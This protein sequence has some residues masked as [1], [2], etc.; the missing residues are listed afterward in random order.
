MFATFTTF[1]RHNSRETRVITA[2]IIFTSERKH[3]RK[4]PSSGKNYSLEFY[5]GT[6]ISDNDNKPSD[7][8]ALFREYKQ[9]PIN[10][11]RIGSSPINK[12]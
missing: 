10:S 11:R 4:M 2:V 3:T 9:K 6:T 8:V 5:E 1:I 12:S 7:S